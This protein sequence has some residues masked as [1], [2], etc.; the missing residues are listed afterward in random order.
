MEEV[1][2]NQ[3]LLHAAHDVC[4]EPGIVAEDP[5]IVDIRVEMQTRWLDRPNPE[6]AA[7]TPRIETHASAEFHA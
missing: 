4:H 6:P 3:F 2:L 5:E 1:L 7:Q